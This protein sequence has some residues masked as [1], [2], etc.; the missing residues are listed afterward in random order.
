LLVQKGIEAL[1][2]VYKTGP[3]DPRVLLELAAVINPSAPF[4]AA[5]S[6]RAW[7]IAKAR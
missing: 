5:G 7:A 1:E 2:N 6:R 3:D 4:S